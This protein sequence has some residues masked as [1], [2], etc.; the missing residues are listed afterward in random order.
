MLQNRYE[1]LYQSSTSAYPQYSGAYP[2]Q[3]VSS[4][5]PPFVR[6]LIL[7][8]ILTIIPPFLG[9]VPLILTFVTNHQWKHGKY[10]SYEKTSKELIKCIVIAGTLEGIF[11][12]LFLLVFFG[13][14]ALCY[15]LASTGY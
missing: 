1:Q 13:M 5:K 11:V 12:G 7:S 2:V 9:V 14:F 4:P 15:G 8:I 10:E 3:P 6:N